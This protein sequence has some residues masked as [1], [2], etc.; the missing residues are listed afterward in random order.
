MRDES[1]HWMGKQTRRE[2][3][4]DPTHSGTGPEEAE[5][6]EGRRSLIRG[7]AH[8]RVPPWSLG[9]DAPITQREAKVEQQ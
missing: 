3:W 4:R 1:D 8:P 5:G 9:P 7:F 2:S 6:H